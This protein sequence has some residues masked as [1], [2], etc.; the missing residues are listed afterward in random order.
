M[1][2]NSIHKGRTFQLIY[3]RNSSISLLIVQFS[4]LVFVPLFKSN[5]KKIRK[6][7]E[8]IAF[9]LCCVL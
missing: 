2:I 5:K 3:E 9:S 4:N 1:L 8:Q 6:E 7:N